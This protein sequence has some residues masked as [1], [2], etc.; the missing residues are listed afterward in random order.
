L[1]AMVRTNPG[2]ATLAAPTLSALNHG[3]SGSPKLSPGSL[4]SVYGQL[5]ARGTELTSTTPWPASMADVVVTINGVVA[6]LYYVSPTQLNGQVP[7][8]TAVGQ[9]TAI[10]RVVGREPVSVTFEVIAANPGIL[11]FNGDRAVVV[12]QDYSVNTGGNP[13]AGGTFGTVYFS[14]IGVPDTAV[15][16]G[17]GAPAAEPLAR[18]KYPSSIRINGQ[19]VEVLYLGLAPTY[20]AL[21]QANFRFP[22]LPPGDYKMVISVNG[23]DSNEAVISIR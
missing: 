14:G 12:N 16:T 4:F 6:P 21:A 1:I 17:E 15:R 7:Y 19:P 13:A 20:P 18:S 23:V 2:V 8:E 9:A 5:L 11:L 3:A 22:S 10:I